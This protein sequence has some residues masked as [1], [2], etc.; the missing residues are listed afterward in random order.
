MRAGSKVLIEDDQI[1]KVAKDKNGI[2]E[3]TILTENQHD[4]IDYQAID[5]N[6]E[7]KK[8]VIKIKNNEGETEK[9]CTGNYLFGN[10]WQSFR[11]KKNPKPEFTSTSHE[12]PKNGKYKIMV[13]VVNIL[14]VDTSKIIEVQ[15]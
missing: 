13:K 3:R 12:Y 11:T 2:I 5:F 6:Y 14:E 1:I 8:E 9:K 15:V 10:E 4:W 7:D